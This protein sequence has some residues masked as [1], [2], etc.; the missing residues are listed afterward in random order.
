MIE[1]ESVIESSLPRLQ[2]I[3]INFVAVYTAMNEYKMQTMD[4]KV[5]QMAISLPEDNWCYMEKLVTDLSL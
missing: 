1:L 5:N 2:V 4:K 3:T